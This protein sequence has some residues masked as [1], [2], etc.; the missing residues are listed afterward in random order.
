[1]PLPAAPKRQARSNYDTNSSLDAADIAS[2]DESYRFEQVPYND[3]LSASAGTSRDGNK[4][5]SHSRS[6]S[7]GG[8][9]ETLGL[10][11]MGS[12]DDFR[13][14][15]EGLKRTTSREREREFRE[16]WKIPGDGGVG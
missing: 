10:P 15:G 12:R 3:L 13:E 11:R 1:M 9:A 2:L 16:R 4:S 6:R 14:F 7:R 8:S 5:H